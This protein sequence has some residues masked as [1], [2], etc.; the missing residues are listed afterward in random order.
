[1]ADT[2]NNKA[3]VLFSGGQDSATCLAYALKHYDAVETIG[4]DYAQ[5]HHVE[6]DIRQVFLRNLVKQFPHWSDKLGSD[7]VLMADVLTSI[8]AT[9]MT[10]A[11]DIQTQANGLPNTFVPG[12]NLLFLVLAGALAYRRGI[13]TLVTGVCETDYSGYPDCRNN[14]MQAMQQ[15]LTL[16]IGQPVAI[17]TPLMYRDKAQTWAWAHALG[18]DALVD[19][20]IEETHTCY[21]GDRSQRHA[22]GYGCD[23]CPACA[24]RSKGWSEWQSKLSG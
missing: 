17:D 13:G 16:G 1:M 8:G 7:H 12:R 4:F 6:L 3:L 19:L 9:A 23:V 20:I 21:V 11:I 10:E 15:A 5:R 18:G 14:T 22:W 2:Q 24:L